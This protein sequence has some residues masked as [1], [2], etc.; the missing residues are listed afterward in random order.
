MKN[1]TLLQKNR[2][3]LRDRSGWIDLTLSKVALMIVSIVLLAA[4]YQIGSDLSG[5]Q[6]Q[7]E[8]DS[9]AIGLKAAIDDIGSSSPDSIRRS[10]AYEL[11]TDFPA[12]AFIS[13]EYIRF[14]TTYRDKTIHSVK[15]LTFRTLPINETEM[16]NLISNNLNGHTGT[17]EDPINIDTTTTLEFFSS[18]SNQ[19]LILNTR[20][21]VHIEKTSI[22]M[23]NDSEVKQLE[24]VLVYQ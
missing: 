2:E 16:R 6:I 21:I 15:P 19:E 11:S 7:K 23:K 12:K 22:Y 14:E 5:M 10:S 18:V 13:G 8:L 17:A 9:E 20:K 4:F 24:I 1:E 3:L